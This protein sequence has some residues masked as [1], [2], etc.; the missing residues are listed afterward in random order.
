MAVEAKRGCGYRKVGGLYMVS[1]RGGM[2]CGRLPWPLDV[3]PTCG[4]GIKQARGWTWIDAS[5]L[6]AG[7]TQ[8]QVTL[9]GLCPVSNAARTGKAGLIWAGEKFYPTPADFLKEAN[10][11]GVSRRIKAIPRGFKVGEHWVLMAHP[12]GCPTGQW[13][14]TICDKPAVAWDNSMDAMQHRLDTGHHVVEDYKAGIFMVFKPTRF[15]KIIT[16]T[17]S[18]DD[19]L[20]ADLKDRG[21]TPVVVPDGDL[22][23]Q[24]SVYDKPEEDLE[25]VSADALV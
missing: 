14:C 18:K 21:I 1:E 24:G 4:H 11:M 9:C 15:E 19:V 13:H 22:D 12:K 2:H 23:H 6:F 5:Q 10:E 17:M 3:C 25:E 8:C 20:M 7:V 16:E